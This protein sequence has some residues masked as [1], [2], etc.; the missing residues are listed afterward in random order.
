MPARAH[1]VAL[2]PSLGVLGWK[3]A[4]FSSA[5]AS[6]ARVNKYFRSQACRWLEQPALSGFFST[7]F[8][9]P[10]S[11]R[12]TRHGTGQ[13]STTIS[14]FRAAPPRCSI[15]PEPAQVLPRGNDCYLQDT[16]RI[17]S[18][19]FGVF[20]PSGFCC[21]SHFA[22][23]ARVLKNQGLLLSHTRDG[24]ATD[25]GFLPPQG[26]SGCHRHPLRLSIWHHGARSS[27]ND[28]NLA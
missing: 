22:P 5:A 14:N 12:L 25:C 16:L 24:S 27:N 26:T 17:T 2:P 15:L 19:P 28:K 7:P 23:R 6:E 4:I 9:L 20:R 1:P 18:T 13:N 10:L 3:R 8:S 11:L 21:V